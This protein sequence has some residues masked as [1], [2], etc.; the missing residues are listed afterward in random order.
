MEGLTRVK[1][2]VK[3]VLFLMKGGCEDC[4]CP[5][6]NPASIAALE[7]VLDVIEHEEAKDDDDTI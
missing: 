4:G 3:R 2:E 7:W 5:K 6:G 1:G